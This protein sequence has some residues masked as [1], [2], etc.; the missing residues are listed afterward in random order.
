MSAAVLGEMLRSPSAIARRCR[1]DDDVRSV[2]LVALASIAIGG[3]VFGAAIGSFRGDAQIAFAAIKLPLVLIAT[4]AI[5][6]PAFHG[7]AA[8]LGRPWPIRTVFAIALAAAGR[9][10]LVLLACAP[11]A[12][13]AFDCGLPYHDSILLTAGAYA[14]AGLAALGVILRGLGDG[15]ARFAT[16]LAFA[17]VFLAV[18]AQTAWILRPW[19]GRPSQEEI[20][21]VRA[22]EGSFGEAVWQSGKSAQGIYDETREVLERREVRR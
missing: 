9:A 14:L 7:L 8:A 11:I 13:L 1:E 18:S 3:A 20:P 15:S 19:I 16:V 22:T 17:A 6:A 2:A 21:F 12:W 4:L 5:C 10:A